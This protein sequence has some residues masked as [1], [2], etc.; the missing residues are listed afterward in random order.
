MHSAGFLILTS[1]PSLIRKYCND[2]FVI[3]RFKI[4][5]MNSVDEAESLLGT[6]RLR[7][8]NGELDH[9]SDVEDSQNLE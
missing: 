5:E 2:V 3:N 1:S 7:E 6:D 8:G 4:L 9:V